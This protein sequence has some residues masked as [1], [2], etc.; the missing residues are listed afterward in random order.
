[1][2]G[3]HGFVLF[4]TKR[5]HSDSYEVDQKPTKTHYE[6]LEP[7]LEFCGMWGCSE[8]EQ[9]ISASRKTKANARYCRPARGTPLLLWTARGKAS[10]PHPTRVDR[11][12]RVPDSLKSNK[13]GMEKLTETTSPTRA[14]TVQ[15]GDTT[16]ALRGQIMKCC[17]NTL[18]KWGKRKWKMNCRG[19]AKQEQDA[20]GGSRE[21]ETSGMVGGMD[22]RRLRQE[23]SPTPPYTM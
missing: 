21:Q 17:F 1:M 13:G 22:F 23:G 11:S 9:E 2:L 5:D 7:W 20:R 6:Q 15:S 19:K 4:K 10:S 8:E 3:R 16:T 14:D 18:P 12:G